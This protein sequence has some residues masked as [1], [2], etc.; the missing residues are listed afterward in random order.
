MTVVFGKETANFGTSPRLSLDLLL[1]VLQDIDR[2]RVICLLAQKRRDPQRKFGQTRIEIQN[3]LI[4][5]ER[6]FHLGVFLQPIQALI[7]PL[8]KQ[9]SAFREFPQQ[10]FHVREVTRQPSDVGVS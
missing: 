2:A 8:G 6:I 10:P 9:P 3:S 7:S 1:R 5:G 4:N